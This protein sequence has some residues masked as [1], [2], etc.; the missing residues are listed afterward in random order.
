MN[1]V[2]TA[3]GGI[4]YVSEMAPKRR[5]PSI[6]AVEPMENPSHG[7]DA[8]TNGERAVRETSPPVLVSRGQLR[9]DFQPIV[10]MRTGSTWGVEAL[11]RAKDPATGETIP[12]LRLFADAERSGLLASF[13]RY[14][15]RHAIERFA[16][17]HKAHDVVLTL[18][19]DTRTLGAVDDDP[20]QFLRTVQRNE[21]AP[22]RVVIE[23]LEGRAPNLDAL[24]RFVEDRKAEGFLI[25]VDDYG[26]GHSNPERLV[27]IEPDIVKIDRALVHGAASSVPRREACRSVA[28]LARAIGALVVAE[29]VE[30]EEDLVELSMMGIDLFQGFLLARPHAEISS[31]T[32]T[33]ELAVA[34]HQ[35]LLRERVEVEL[36]RRRELRLRD[37]RV[38]SAVAAQLVR[39]SLGSLELTAADVLDAVQGLEALYVLDERGIQLTSTWLRVDGPR[40]ASFRPAAAGSDLALQDYFLGVA[41][42]SQAYVTRPYVSMASGRMAV[43]YSRRATLRDGCVVIVCC[44][45]PSP[46][47]FRPA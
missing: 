22:E 9:T 5:T 45:I 19:W 31:G 26:T 32:A 47:D 30:R 27:R 7:D 15:R 6:P 28:E 37:E 38:V 40:R 3:R 36:D 11:S 33:A 17:S 24:V 14:C 34:S 2:R 10:S 8:G 20:R 35:P 23:V 42:G 29:G 43:T 21:I 44:D 1:A 41:D 12:P 4:L 13:D 25:A 18:N 39:A 46:V 16:A